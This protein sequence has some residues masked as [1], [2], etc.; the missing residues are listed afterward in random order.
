[1]AVCDETWPAAAGAFRGSLA[2]LRA[3]QGAFDEARTLL[4]RGEQQLRGVYALEL[5]KLLCKR[6]EVERLAGDLDAARAALD[7]AASI[8]ARVEAG[9][10]SNL[11][12]TVA[13]L[14]AGLDQ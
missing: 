2:L 1:V 11:G 4:T 9:P 5:G 13:V 7:E 3:R 10:D 12:R 6:G 8:A 14:S